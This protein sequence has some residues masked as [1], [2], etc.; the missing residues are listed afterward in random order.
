MADKERRLAIAAR[1]VGADDSGDP[2]DLFIVIDGSPDCYRRA[3]RRRDLPPESS[4]RCFL[5]SVMGSDGVV[6]TP[7]PGGQL[8]L[9]K[10]TCGAPQQVVVPEAPVKG[11]AVKGWRETKEFGS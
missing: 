5:N 7:M 4:C 3:V 9:A 1:H 11:S 2:E 10:H 8:V 6:R